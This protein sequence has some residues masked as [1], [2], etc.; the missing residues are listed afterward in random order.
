MKKISMIIVSQLIKSGVI[1]EEDREVY[2]YAAYSV[3]LQALPLVLTL[4]ISVPLGKCM[5]GICFIFPFMVLRKYSGGLHLKSAV[6]CTII[7]FCVLVIGVHLTGILYPGTVLNIMFGTAICTLVILSPI[8]SENRRLDDDEKVNCKKIVV[9]LSALF[10]LIYC[11][12]LL[13]NSRLSVCIA[14]GVI[15]TALLQLLHY[16]SVKL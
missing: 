7:S 12:M 10:S 16:F 2:E 3:M 11:I 1:C 15:M 4:I 13:L 8:D 9:I 6:A 5:Q 14:E